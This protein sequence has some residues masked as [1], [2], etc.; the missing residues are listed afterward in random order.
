MRNKPASSMQKTKDDCDLI[1][2][3][4]VYYEGQVDDPTT[5]MTVLVADLFV[6][7]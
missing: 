2:A 3:T 1:C 7:E 4:A 5:P 6:L